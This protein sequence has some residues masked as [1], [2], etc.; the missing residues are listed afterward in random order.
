MPDEM[1]KKLRRL[2]PKQQAF[3]KA[4]L[5]PGM[6]QT[7]AYMDVYGS[8]VRTTAAVA[9]S[10]LAAR[11]HVQQHIADV[12]ADK[13]P[14]AASEAMEVLR[15]YVRDPEVAPSVKLK[16]LELLAKFMAWNAPNKSM[17]I[18][19][20]VDAKKYKLPGSQDE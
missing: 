5:Q 14:E 13:Y 1:P 12:I 15:G 9:A 20:K 19:A 16:S 11:P 18:H 7:Q 4:V 17:H 3:A 8:K 6:S 10:E 2:T